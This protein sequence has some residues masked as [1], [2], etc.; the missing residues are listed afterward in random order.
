MISWRRTR[1]IAHKEYLHVVR[2]LRSLLLA[3]VLP[4][5]LLMLFGYALTLDVD[6]GAGREAADDR[7]KGPAGESRRLVDLRPDDL[8]CFR[9]GHLRGSFVDVG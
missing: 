7:E 1:A 8:L 4:L 6:A 2:D 5:F 3:L 9:F